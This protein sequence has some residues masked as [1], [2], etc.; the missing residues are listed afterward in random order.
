MK[1]EEVEL[2]H[3]NVLTLLKLVS[4]IW[5]FQAG[6]LRTSSWFTIDREQL[7]DAN[8]RY[9]MDLSVTDGKYY[10]KETLYIDITNENESPVFLQKYYSV[11]TT[12]G[13]VGKG[14]GVF[15]V[16]DSVGWAFEIND[17]NQVR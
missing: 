7:Q 16:N 6:E 4:C 15:L 12:E 9:R 3:K 11:S 10:D 14:A 1:T 13:P 2:H 5:Q 8:N 17:F